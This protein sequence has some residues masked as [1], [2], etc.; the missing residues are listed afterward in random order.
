MQRNE[1]INQNT[2]EYHRKCK[3]L[4]VGKE[5]NKSGKTS[6]LRQE[7]W[8]KCLS[9]RVFW[10]EEVPF[11]SAVLPIGSTVFP[12][13]TL[14]FLANSAWG[15][16]LKGNIKEPNSFDR[17]AANSSTDRPSSTQSPGRFPE[18]ISFLFEDS[19]Y[20]P[21]YFQYSCFI[22]KTLVKKTNIERFPIDGKDCCLCCC[23]E[24]LSIPFTPVFFRLLGQCSLLKFN[25]NY[26][27]DIFSLVFFLFLTNPGKWKIKG[28]LGSRPIID[29]HCSRYNYTVTIIV[30]HQRGH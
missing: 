17:T 25:E 13:W 19:T 21:K 23:C 22:K 26:F 4:L 6:K 28:K 27:S 1:W 30:A 12:C 2:S 16:N 24:R 3:T 5:L 20:S 10:T 14:D 29:F 7:E 8:E 9:S 15:D 11:F 18:A